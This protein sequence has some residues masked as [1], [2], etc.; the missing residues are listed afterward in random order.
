MM[1]GPFPKGQ[2]TIREL[3]VDIHGNR[4]INIV[5]TI[6]GLPDQFEA[7]ND[8]ELSPDIGAVGGVRLNLIRPGHEVIKIEI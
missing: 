4:I 5:G 7:S 3:G 6:T 1:E 8:Y 2:V